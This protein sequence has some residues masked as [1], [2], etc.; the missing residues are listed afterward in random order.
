ML[1]VEWK[2]VKEIAYIVWTTI[3]MV[4][5]NP[6]IFETCFFWSNLSILIVGDVQN[7]YG[8]INGNIKV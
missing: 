8:S 1:E 5:L 6:S 4:G 2:W 7:I 3:I